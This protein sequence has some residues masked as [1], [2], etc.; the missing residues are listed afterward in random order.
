MRVRDA[1]Q[2]FL[3]LWIRQ[4]LAGEEMLVFGDGSQ[5]RDFT[6]V[7]DAVRAFCLAA[8][9]PA[10]VGEAFN[11]GGQGHASLLEIA[12]LVVRLAGSGSFRVVPFPEDRLAIDI[13]DYYADDRKLRTRVDWR[14]KVGLKEGL[15]ETIDFYRNYGEA[16]WGERA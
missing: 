11:V 12:D 15:A 1:R 10:A 3:G 16:Y 6:Y 5:R 7:D 8:A 4:A 13:G 2:T 14:P 9:S